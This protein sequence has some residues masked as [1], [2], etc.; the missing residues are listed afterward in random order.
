MVEVKK[1]DG[2]IEDFIESKIIAACEKAGSTAEQ[3]ACVVLDVVEKIGDAALISTEEL[4]ELVES[5]LRKVNEG[6]ADAFLTYKEE[7]YRP[8]AD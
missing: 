7:K 4:S 1:R 8:D 3:A 5:S 6:A 2:S